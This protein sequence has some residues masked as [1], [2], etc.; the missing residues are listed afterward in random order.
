MFKGEFTH[1]MDAKGRIIIPAK[2]REQLTGSFV[3]CKGLDNCLWLLE[4]AEWQRIVDALNALPFTV[5]E[6]RTLV[7]FLM[8]G[9]IDGEMD[10]Q[11]RVLLSQAL[12]DHGCLNAGEDVVFAGVG[13]KVE[14]WNK[15]KYADAAVLDDTSMDAV[16]EK[17]SEMGIRL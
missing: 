16:A 15:E 3:V 5:K 7:R 11:G 12:R 1:A 9:A 4:E 17:L 6:A 8:A 14:I 13:N 2:L 10:K